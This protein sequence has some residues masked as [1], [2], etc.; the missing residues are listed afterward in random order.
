MNRVNNQI[1]ESSVIVIDVDGTNL[2]TLA[3]GEAVKLARSKDLDL[4]EV[5]RGVCKIQ[6]WEKFRYQQQKAHKSKPA[7]ELKE[8]RFGATI[9][10]HDLDTKVRQINEL[11]QKGHPIKVVVR[12]VG[13]ENAHPEKGVEVI[14]KIKKRLVD[15]TMDPHKQEGNTTIAHI[16]RSS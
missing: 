13:R 9:H 3:T 1:T 4:I 11:V 8:F 5:G 7:P 15:A 14:E 16:R 10:D 6:S 12:L 2:G